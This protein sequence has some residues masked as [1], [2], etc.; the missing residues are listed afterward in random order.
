VIVG[1]EL[2]QVGLQTKLSHLELLCTTSQPAPSDLKADTIQI[3]LSRPCSLLDPV[4]FIVA[5]KR[6][7]NTGALEVY[8]SAL[9]LP[10]T[11]I[12]DI[13]NHFNW[14]RRG[15]RKTRPEVADASNGHMI[16]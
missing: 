11:R 3:H 6:A 2:V 14:L 12:I 1:S 4:L 7:G 9:L 13:A 5:N 15:Q 8:D 16:L 10:S